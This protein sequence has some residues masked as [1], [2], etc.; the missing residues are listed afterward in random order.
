MFSMFTSVVSIFFFFKHF[1]ACLAFKKKKSEF[2]TFQ[3]RLN[4]NIWTSIRKVIIVFFTRC[5]FCEIKENEN[6]ENMISCSGSN[7]CLCLMGKNKQIILNICAK[8]S[9]DQ[10]VIR[11]KNGETHKGQPLTEIHPER[12]KTMERRNSSSPVRSSTL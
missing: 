3:D 7:K 12:T 10:T 6:A 9:H 11:A 1:S 8:L 4:S 5:V 2:Y